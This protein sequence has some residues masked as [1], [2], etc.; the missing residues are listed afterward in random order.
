MVAEGHY[1]WMHSL[2]LRPLPLTL[3]VRVCVQEHP[4][5]LPQAVLWSMHASSCIYTP[6]LTHIKKCQN[7]T[8]FWASGF[9]VGKVGPWST[10]ACLMG[11]LW[12]LNSIRRCNEQKDKTQA[13][14]LRF[15]PAL[16]KVVL[17]GVPSFSLLSLGTFKYLNYVVLWSFPFKC[18]FL[19]IC[20]LLVVS[21]P[22]M[23]T[24]F[25]DFFF[26]CHWGELSSKES[27]RNC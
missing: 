8:H 21:S 11:F 2:K 19:H 18:W 14:L 26:R 10:S 6:T 25:R 20:I 7:K 12:G 24:V 16:G 3:C 5:V 9:S 4:T 17:S 15:Y 22:G 13:G 1:R 23:L 27:P